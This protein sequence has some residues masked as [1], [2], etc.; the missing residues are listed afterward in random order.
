M[1]KAVRKYYSTSVRAAAVVDG[2]FEAVADDLPFERDDEVALMINGLGGT[3]LSTEFMQ[4][5]LESGIAHHRSIAFGRALD[6]RVGAAKP[7]ERAETCSSLSLGFSLF[8]FGSPGF[9]SA[10]AVAHSCSLFAETDPF[11]IVSRRAR[12]ALVRSKTLRTACLTP[13]TAR[14]IA[15]N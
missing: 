5:P 1:F 8:T 11:R 15:A 6:P 4:R 14:A 7:P 10:K 9:Q 12:H 3:P 13:F 2:L